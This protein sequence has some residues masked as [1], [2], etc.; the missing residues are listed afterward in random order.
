MC[1]NGYFF[2]IFSGDLASDKPF[3]RAQEIRIIPSTVGEIHV[4]ILV[5][6]GIYLY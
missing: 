6:A 4:C 5:Y 2:T 1:K 3:S